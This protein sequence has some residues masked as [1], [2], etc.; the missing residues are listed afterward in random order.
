MKKIINHKIYAVV[1]EQGTI[2]DKFVNKQTA[3]NHMPRL[4]LTKH[5]KLKVVEI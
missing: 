4:K 5:E 2:L 1:D 3:R